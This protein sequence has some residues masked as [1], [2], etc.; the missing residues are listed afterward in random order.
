MSLVP[1]VLLFPIAG[2]TI[3]LL[4]VIVLSAPLFTITRN[5]HFFYVYYDEVEKV[6]VNVRV[7]VSKNYNIYKNPSCLRHII[8]TK[9]TAPTK[10]K[11]L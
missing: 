6:A 7:C 11:D 1:S 10:K 3:A 2:M 8:Q 4:R 9:R 5:H